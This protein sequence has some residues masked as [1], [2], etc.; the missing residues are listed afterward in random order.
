M[1]SY[2]IFECSL[3]GHQYQV[4]WGWILT[5]Y[6]EGLGL[7]DSDYYYGVITCPHCNVSRSGRVIQDIFGKRQDDKKQG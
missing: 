4:E 5:L 6:R 3:C 2:L 1:L 7:G